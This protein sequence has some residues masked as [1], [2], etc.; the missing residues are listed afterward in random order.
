[1]V[2]HFKF[3]ADFLSNHHP[4]KYTHSNAM[5]EHAP[6]GFCMK[7][8]SCCRKRE[9]AVCLAPGVR[10]SKLNVSA[11]QTDLEASEDGVR[12]KLDENKTGP[13]ASLRDFV[14]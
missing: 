5:Y 13:L 9:L 14:E 7:N 4:I 8:P 3:L 1:M 2:G 11:G 10:L 6:G 12:Y